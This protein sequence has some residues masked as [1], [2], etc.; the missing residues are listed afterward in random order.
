MIRRSDI[1]VNELLLKIDNN[2]YVEKCSLFVWG[3]LIYA[4]SFSV[5]FSSH[6]IVTGGSTGLSI[7]VNNVFGIL[8]VIWKFLLSIG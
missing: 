1:D 3:V 6:D 4:L 8:L 5:F 2:N 7:I